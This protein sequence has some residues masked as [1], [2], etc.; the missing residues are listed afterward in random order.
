MSIV[1][2]LFGFHGRLRRRDCWLFGI[3]LAIVAFC[4][5]AIGMAMMD[6]LV[7]PYLGANRA[8]AFNASLY[9]WMLAQQ[10]ALVILLWPGLAVGVK[11]MHDRNRSG[12]WLA[13]FVVLFWI[14]QV[15]RMVVLKGAGDGLGTPQTGVPGML[16]IGALVVVGL[17]LFVELGL[18]GGTRGPNRFGESPKGDAAPYASP[19]PQGSDAV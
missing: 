19:L 9:Y 18:L 2:K 16:L 5:T 6:D 10:G 1:Q 14:Q 8:L 3:L 15:W 12:W 11:R 7:R 17:W 13:P 4:L